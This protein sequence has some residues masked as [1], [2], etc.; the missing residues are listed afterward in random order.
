MEIRN[1]LRPKEGDSGEDQIQEH[2]QHFD[3]KGIVHNEFVL[4]DQTANSAYYCDVLRRLC[5]NVRRL[6]PELWE[7]KNWLLHQDNAVSHFIFRQEYFANDC[8]SHPPYFS[9]FPR[10]KTK[11]KGR[12]FDRNE[13]IEAESQAVLNTFTEHDFQDAI[14]K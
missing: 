11:L 8:R 5:E 9:L 2:A 7:Q 3:F 6:R 10:L 13:V 1:M 14:E 4:V 12:Y